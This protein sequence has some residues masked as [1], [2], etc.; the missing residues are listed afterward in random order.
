MHRTC[1]LVEEEDGTDLV[2]RLLP[3]NWDGFLVG[4]PFLYVQVS[5]LAQKYANAIL[6]LGDI[7][8]NYNNNEGT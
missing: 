7:Y 1:W 5:V 6:S 8:N 2:V 3:R 4:K